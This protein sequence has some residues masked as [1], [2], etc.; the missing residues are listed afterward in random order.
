MVAATTCTLFPHAQKARITLTARGE[1]VPVGKPLHI[2][3]PGVRVRIGVPHDTWTSSLRKRGGSSRQR[4]DAGTRQEV[5]GC[6]SN[7]LPKAEGA[8]VAAGPLS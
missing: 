1:S 6:M 4:V 2:H 3:R 8:L 7:N 5:L